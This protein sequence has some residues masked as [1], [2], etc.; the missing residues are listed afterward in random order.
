VDASISF[1]L[2]NVMQLTYVFK[3]YNGESEATLCSCFI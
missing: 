3:T 2:A 1:S